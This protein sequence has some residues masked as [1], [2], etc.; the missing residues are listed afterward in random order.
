MLDKPATGRPDTLGVHTT[1]CS[2]DVFVGVDRNIKVMERPGKIAW[3]GR[4]LG[5]MRVQHS[6]DLSTAAALILRLSR[7]RLSTSMLSVIRIRL[8][9]TGKRSV[10]ILAVHP[11]RVIKQR[12][13]GSEQSRLGCRAHRRTDDSILSI[14]PRS[15]QASQ[16]AGNLAQARLTSGHAQISTVSRNSRLCGVGR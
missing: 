10:G 16:P 1:G 6:G 9:V 7:T 11:Q 3:N 12:Q 15:C 4:R 14:M 8:T 13:L 5:E 2:R